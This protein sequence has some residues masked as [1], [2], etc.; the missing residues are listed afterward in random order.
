MSRLCIV[1]DVPDER[2]PIL[3]HAVALNAATSAMG[4]LRSAYVLTKAKPRNW[5]ERAQDAL[6]IERNQITE[7]HPTTY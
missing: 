4:D 1:I 5:L 3:L 2:L 7:L 6:G